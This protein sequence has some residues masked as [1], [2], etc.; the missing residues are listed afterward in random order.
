MRITKL[1]NQIRFLMKI[2]QYIVLKVVMRGNSFNKKRCHKG[3]KSPKNRIK[4]IKNPRLSVFSLANP[5]HPCAILPMYKSPIFVGLQV[6]CTSSI[7]YRLSL[8]LVEMKTLGFN[9]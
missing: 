9:H 1:D 4:K 5:C 2:T 8:L 3:T 7:R 6:R